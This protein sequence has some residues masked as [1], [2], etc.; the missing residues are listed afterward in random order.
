MNGQFLSFLNGT[1]FRRVNADAYERSMRRRRVV[2]AVFTWA[3]VA[4]VAWVVLESAQAL[5]MF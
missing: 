1:Q 4:G 3:A 5:T 2:M